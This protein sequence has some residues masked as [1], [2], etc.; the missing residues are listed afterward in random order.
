MATALPDDVLALV[1]DELAR[2]GH[3]YESYVA[4]QETLRS[5]CL[6][7]R[8]LYRLAQPSLWRQVAIYSPDQ[9]ERFRA[10]PQADAL[11]RRTRSYTVF[12]SSVLKLSE[13]VAMS[14]LLPEVVD[15]RVQSGP[16]FPFRLASL[17]QHTSAS[18]SCSPGSYSAQ[19][20]CLRA[21]LPPYCRSAPPRRRNGEPAGRQLRDAPDA[22]GAL[23]P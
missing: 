23:H 8:K 13:S 11:G 22:R 17:E 2:P 21:P 4:R 18:S 3:T 5:A 14:A 19:V 20:R 10:S 7:S 9:L 1:H 16:L 6:V 12:S 15:V